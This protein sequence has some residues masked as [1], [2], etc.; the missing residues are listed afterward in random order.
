MATG[1]EYIPAG[2]K[3]ASISTSIERRN[4]RPEQLLGALVY[5][6]QEEV[7]ITEAD[8]IRA[9]GT[10]IEIECIEGP[11]GRNYTLRKIGKG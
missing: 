9:E 10:M 8:L 3:P 2:L 11:K 6:S 7:V 5:R 1:D 4:I